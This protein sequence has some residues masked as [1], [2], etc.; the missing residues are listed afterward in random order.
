VFTA[1]PYF[2]GN[3]KLERAITRPLA[4]EEERFA[5]IVELAGGRSEAKE[6]A[7]EREKNGTSGLHGGGY[8][9]PHDTNNDSFSSTYVVFE[10][11]RTA[12][13]LP[14]GPLASRG[15]FVE[16]FLFYPTP[17]LFLVA[18]H[19][20]ATQRPGAVWALVVELGPASPRRPN[21]S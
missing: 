10:H 8:F 6:K 17:A 21:E 1:F 12:H 4:R 14:A 2:L 7:Q 13:H 15:A 19:L 16:L 18:A 20:A 11:L 5:H 3:H 9:A